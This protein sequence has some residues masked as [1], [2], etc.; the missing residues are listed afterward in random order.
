MEVQR[1]HQIMVSCLMNLSL[2]VKP[3]SKAGY[4]ILSW[5]DSEIEDCDYGGHYRNFP[6]HKENRTHIVNDLSLIHISEP[7]RP[8]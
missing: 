2:E 3:W 4:E 8:Y 5:I 7:T 1:E 6:G